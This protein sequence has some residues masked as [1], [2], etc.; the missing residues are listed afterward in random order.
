[1]ASAVTLVE[2]Q[3]LTILGIRLSELES[4]VLQSDSR[5]SVEAEEEETDDEYEEKNIFEAQILEGVFLFTYYTC[6][7]CP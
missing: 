3:A 6:A 4:M 5:M 1:M 2:S 7:S